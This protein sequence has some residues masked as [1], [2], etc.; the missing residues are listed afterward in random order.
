[1]TKFRV[2]PHEGHETDVVADACGIYDDVAVFELAGQT[3]AAFAKGAW[4]SIIKVEPDDKSIEGLTETEQ[5][6]DYQAAR[7]RSEARG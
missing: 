3:V 1:M 2:T 5:E 6:A 4:A 7:A